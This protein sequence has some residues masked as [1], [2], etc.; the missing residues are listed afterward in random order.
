MY[1]E[2][3]CSEIN[4]QIKT[5][6]QD[7]VYGSVL[8]SSYKSRNGWIEDNSGSIVYE[9]KHIGK[10]WKE[11]MEKLYDEIEL[12]E[13]ELALEQEVDEEMILPILREKF[14]KALRNIK[15]RKVAGIDGIQAELWKDEQIYNELFKLV[16]DIYN[17]GNLPLDFVKYNIISIPK[18]PTET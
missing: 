2:E 1:L 9:K 5:G 6:N 11:Y 14:D 3:N 12:T 18:K 15:T 16:N 10:V 7:A 13:D 8:F 4:V 17:T